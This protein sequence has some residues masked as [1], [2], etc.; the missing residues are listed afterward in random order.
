LLSEVIDFLTATNMN[1]LTKGFFACVFF[2]FVSFD[3]LAQF[4]QDG[5]CPNR[6][7][8][9]YVGDGRVELS[10]QGACNDL[11]VTWS[12]GNGQTYVSAPNIT[13]NY[14]ELLEY[15]ASA[16]FTD[17]DCAGP[18][19]ISVNIN[20][21]PFA[22]PTAIT[23]TVVECSAYSFSLDIPDPTYSILWDF[24]ALGV[25]NVNDV[26]QALPVGS[27]TISVTYSSANCATTV[28]TTTINAPDCSNQNCLNSFSVA[29][30]STTC[31]ASTISINGFVG[32]TIQW[33]INNQTIT[34]N[35]PLTTTFPGPGT[36]VGSAF[37][38]NYGCTNGSLINLN[39]TVSDCDMSNCPQSL[40]PT[41]F[42]CGLFAFEMS[43]LVVGSTSTWTYGD[44]NTGAGTSSST[45]QFTQSNDY[46]VCGTFTN[47]TCTLGQ[48]VCRQ[49]NATVCT[50]GICPQNLVATNTQLSEFQFSIQ[51]AEAGEQVLWDFG[52]SISQNGGSTISYTYAFPGTYTVTASFS[53]S[54]C[55]NPNII[56]STTITVTNVT[57]VC[58]TSI[59]VTPNA[60]CGLYGFSL[61]GPVTDGASVEWTFGDGL[62]ASN[63]NSVSHQFSNQGSYTITA[64]YNSISC[65]NGI[66]LTTINVPDCS[67]PTICPT[68]LSV[69]STATCG[70]YNFSAGNAVPGE[71]ATW[72]F[73]D[74]S[75]FTGN[76]ATS[77]QFPGGGS[78]Q[79]CVFITNSQ[80]PNGVALCQNV[81][82]PA[83][84]YNCGL[85]VVVLE[86]YC[87]GRFVLNPSGASANATIA[88]TLNGNAINSG[89]N[90]DQFLAPGNYTACASYNSADCTNPPSDCINF[91]VDACTGVVCPTFINSTTTNNC[92]EYLFS[93]STGA[94]NEN[95]VWTFD[96]VQVNGGATI[97]RAFSSA[98]VHNICATYTSAQCTQPTN[99]CTTVTSIQCNNCPSAISVVSAECQFIQLQVGSASVPATVLWNFGDGSAPF[100]S[101]YIQGH[102]Y[103]LGGNYTVSATYT[104]I[105]CP[106]GVTLTYN[107]SLENCQ[108]VCEIA[109]DTINTTCSG[110]TVVATTSPDQ[111]EV[112]WTFNGNAVG[113]GQTKTFT[114]LNPGTYELCA[115]I[116][117][118]LCP[119]GYTFCRDIVLA[120]CTPDIC[121]TNIIN[122][123]FGD[124]GTYL[125]TIQNATVDA[126][127]VWHFPGGVNIT[128]N[129][130]QAFT[131]SGSGTF[132]ITADY[133]SQA[134][135]SGSTLTGQI[136]VPPCQVPCSI[137]IFSN[138]SVCGQINYSSNISPAG[139]TVTWNLNGN[140][141]GTGPSIS[142][143]ATPGSYQLCGIINSTSCTSVVQDCKTAVVTSCFQCPT[144]ITSAQGDTC[145]QYI[146][147]IPNAQPGAS[148][149]WTFPGGIVLTGG[150]SITYQF[151][152]F[153]NLTL[154]ANYT[155]SLCPAGVNLST[156]LQVPQCFPP[157]SIDIA[158]LSQNC[159]GAS[160]QALAPAGASVQWNINGSN[161]GTG[162]FYNFLGTNNTYQV[163]ASFNGASTCTGPAS[164]CLSVAIDTCPPCT[165]E[166]AAE[167]MPLGSASPFTYTFN[168]SGSANVSSYSWN[169][170]DGNTL[171]TSVPTATHTYASAGQFAACVTGEDPG[172]G[173]VNACA[174]IVIAQ[175]AC[176]DPI[177]FHLRNYAGG[178]EI[179]GVQINVLNY[180]GDVVQTDNFQFS[181]THPDTIVA[182]CLPVGCY[183]FR[184]NFSQDLI[185]DFSDHVQYGGGFVSDQLLITSPSLASVNFGIGWQCDQACGLQLQAYSTE[186]PGQVAVQ[187]LPEPTAD[188]YA[189]TID[190]GNGPEPVVA[191]VLPAHL[192]QENGTYEICV[193]TTRT[194]GCQD[195]SCVQVNVFNAP[196]NCTVNNISMVWS[197]TFN[198]GESE[199]INLQLIE[200]NSVLQSFQLSANGQIQAM[201][202]CLPNGCYELAASP[203][204]GYPM[205]TNE[206]NFFFSQNGNALDTLTLTNPAAT[207]DTLANLR[208][209]PTCPNGL[210]ESSFASLELYPNP[211]QD[212]FVINHNLQGFVL[213]EM[214]DMHGRIV[215]SKRTTNGLVLTSVADLPDGLYLVRITSDQGQI[216]QRI[217]VIH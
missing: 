47:N 8:W 169:F 45:H 114:N 201:P 34:N 168:V 43:P 26:I 207:A 143:P 184:F 181:F 135:N 50:D 117:T 105:T 108:P 3:S 28:L 32:G 166:L 69:S 21:L 146:F 196:G 187:I 14:G 58:P 161:S 48:Q 185:A 63:V 38:Q 94:Q 23:A 177:Y 194:P 215:H 10:V 60:T 180:V 39:V 152:T 5:I 13:V 191:G 178:N 118:D 74:G 163:C 156:T 19:T 212:A 87:G 11:Q 204:N 110:F 139:N 91:T 115:S 77:Y 134:C 160:L 145:G 46:T 112:S 52:N 176:S 36:Y 182:Y 78:Y 148:V 41:S 142:I 29:P 123:Q 206:I 16:T 27:N 158:I 208:L 22:C 68:S 126:Q 183:T 121:P 35:G 125:F 116:I 154:T 30:S 61:Q 157:C 138:A 200:N 2:A 66:I 102:N 133:F 153:G 140:A 1:L 173:Q 64:T 71:S 82:V 88:W 56:L 59:A 79:A 37:V 132:T 190:F 65:V 18:V 113:T 4:C 216:S 80:C 128:G 96:G 131:F 189:A 90:F 188:G 120:D 97:L 72:S 93:V 150:P 170:G 42:G 57:N 83:C 100:S 89:Y 144:S 7:N 62:G 95:V 86:S 84:N 205:T 106:S 127:V 119:D 99:L 130:A 164:E 20:L 141:V 137:V 55:L 31:F 124:C 129:G 172:C 147:T 25:S 195:T 44:G 40:V 209:D 136:T 53:D 12:P 159:Q 73:S 75:N 210:F 24:G 67:V 76:H 174:Q 70:L 111:L 198:Q 85:D 149:S 211:A 49:I 162:Y 33:N 202:L 192:F 155:S 81:T 104:S 107:A 193:V 203:R 197:G 109:I 199:L 186:V 6:L 17:P 98:G 214:I 217:E 151:S 213:I 54:D 92:G 15:T 171:V 101:A 179:G 9:T 175:P 51:N 167:P 165:F 122:T 103:N